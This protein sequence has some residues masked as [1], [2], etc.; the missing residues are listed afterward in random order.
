MCKLLFV[1]G[2]QVVLAMLQM[3]AQFI[4]AVFRLCN[5]NYMYVHVYVFESCIIMKVSDQMNNWLDRSEK[6]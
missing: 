1:S 6:F 3:G 2:T 4:V 5:Y